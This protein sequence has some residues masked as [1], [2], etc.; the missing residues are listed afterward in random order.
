MAFSLIHELGHLICGIFLGFKPDKMEILP[1]GLK[2]NFKI[3]PD[4]YNKKVRKGTFL[5]IKRIILAL[6]GPITNLICIA[7]TYII[8]KYIVGMNLVL[9]NESTNFKTY[10]NIIY[11]NLLIAIFN[12]LP[13]YPLD[14]GRIIKEIVHI[15]LGIRKSYSYI[16][17]ISEI[18]LYILTI[19]T[20]ILILYYKNIVMITVL[21]YLWL[22]VYRTK[23]EVRMKEKIYKKIE[24]L[25]YYVNEF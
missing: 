12:L 15:K 18:T 24:K 6:A 10:Q 1:Y 8:A 22:I 2:I 25:L 20:S 21:A 7:I 16:E 4:D 11:S 23:K 3:E 5:N 9:N 17:T 14:G 13:I 19:I